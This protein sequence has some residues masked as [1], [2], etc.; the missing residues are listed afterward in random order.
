MGRVARPAPQHIDSAIH[1]ALDD[2]ETAWAVALLRSLAHDAVRPTG[3]KFKTFAS[4]PAS[5]R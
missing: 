3:R 1:A 5:R 4:R 2:L